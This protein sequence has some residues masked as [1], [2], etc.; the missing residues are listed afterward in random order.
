MEE[1]KYTATGNTAGNTIDILSLL[2]TLKQRKKVFY[3]V[4]PITF[5]LSAALILCVP[6]RYTCDVILAP[7]P[8]NGS[9]SSSLQSLASSF[10][11]D[12]SS[13]MSTDAIYPQIYPDVVQ[14]PD[15]ITKLFDIPVITADGEFEG[16]LYQFMLKKHKRTFW[17]KWKGKVSKALRP[18][19]A[20]IV[21]AKSG[22]GFDLF[23]MS[24]PQWYV[25]DLLQKTI[26]CSV[27][28]K[29]DVITFSVT[30]QDQLVC[31]L[32]ADSV[33]S[34]LQAFI[35]D[36]R[37]I[38]NRTDLKYYGEVMQYAY[39]EYQQAC[40]NYIRYADSHGETTLQQYRVEIKNL[41][42]E[43][44][45]KQAAYTSF[46]K[47]YLA[48]QARIQENTPVFTVLQSASIPPQPSGPRRAIFVLFMLFLATIVTS[49]V[50]CK[51]QL[52][53]ILLTPNE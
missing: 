47:Q 21:G 45:I 22:D 7:E 30:M 18:K 12:M 42:S 6:R 37:T 15:F 39:E 28:K 5:V 43:M 48:T 11:F 53:A 38:K 27:D 19:P 41:E 40:Q 13:M 46:Q 29:T 44:Q 10:G 1:A 50:L 23:N 20:P 35:T 3:W 32:V 26:R 17:K 31:A 24:E 4:L 2:R 33:C 36:Y 9:S 34:A 49:C 16:T 14:S 52:T 25:T 51:D 8:V